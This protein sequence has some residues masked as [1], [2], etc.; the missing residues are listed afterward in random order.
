MSDTKTSMQWFFPYILSIEGL[1]RLD[2]EKPDSPVMC[3]SHG[4]RLGETQFSS[5]GLTHSARLVT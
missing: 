4:V 1:T 2:W 3:A 5:G